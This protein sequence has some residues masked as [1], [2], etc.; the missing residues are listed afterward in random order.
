MGDETSCTIL[1]DSGLADILVSVGAFDRAGT[2]KSFF[3]LFAKSLVV[4]SKVRAGA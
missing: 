2:E 4:E 3:F 1:V